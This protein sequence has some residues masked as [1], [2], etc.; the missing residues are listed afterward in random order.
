MGMFRFGSNKVNSPKLECTAR[1]QPN[2]GWICEWFD[3][4][5]QL[6]ARGNDG[7]LSFNLTQDNDSDLLRLARKAI[8]AEVCAA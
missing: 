8:S 3:V 1:F 4:R 5:G 2:H 7:K 6:V